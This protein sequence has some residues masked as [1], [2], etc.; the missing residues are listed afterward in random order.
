MSPSLRRVLLVSYFFPPRFSV[1][2][3]RVC[4]RVLGAEPR[5]R[6]FGSNSPV[7]DGRVAVLARKDDDRGGWIAV[8]LAAAT[9]FGVGMWLTRGTTLYLDDFSLYEANRGLDL[10]VL[11]TPLN[12][13]LLLV[14]RL[15]WA[16]VLALF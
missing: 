6:C 4:C 10:H 13:H 15:I 14:P 1:G 9:S 5:R 12:D 16:A 3:K 11:L 8:A 2:G 7:C